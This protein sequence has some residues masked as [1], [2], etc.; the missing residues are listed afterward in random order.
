MDKEKTLR[1]MMKP[2]TWHEIEKMMMDAG[3]KT[4]Q[5]FW[6]NQLFVGAMAVK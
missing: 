1:S 5:P 3:F 6:R 2:N 4:I